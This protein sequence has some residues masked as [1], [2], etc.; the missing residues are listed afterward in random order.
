MSSVV[1][2]SLF[3]LDIAE[4]QNSIQIKLPDEVNTITQFL[5]LLLLLKASASKAIGYSNFIKLAL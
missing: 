2:K 1:Y 3:N 4:K 5:L